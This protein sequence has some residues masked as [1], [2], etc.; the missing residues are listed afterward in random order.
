MH[1]EGIIIREGFDAMDFARVH[2]WLAAS[3]WTPGIPRERVERGT[4]NSALVIGAFAK[5]GS[6]VGFARVVS[7]K[8]RFAYLCDVVVYAAFRRRGLAQ[9]LVRYALE[10]PEFA[11]VSTWTLA[12]RDAHAVYAPLGFRPVTD[13]ES[14]PDDWM[15]L[16]RV[17]G[18]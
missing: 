9:A 7:D 6:Q 2:A 1:T 17:P 14:R 8:S 13:P 5:D 11:T 12:T 16:R 3:Y 10:H 18:P 15:I 4:R